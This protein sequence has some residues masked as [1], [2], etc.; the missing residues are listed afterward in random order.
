MV[1]QIIFFRNYFYEFFDKQTPKTQKK[2]DFVLDLVA[3]ADRIPEQ[4]FKHLEG[5]AGLYEIRVQHGNNAF[6][7]FCCFDQGK[8][9]VLFNGFVKETDKT[10]KQELKRAERMKQEYFNEKS[11]TK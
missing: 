5:T 10:P 11:K 4:Y 3:F 9:V 6:R 8:V 7:I 2:I 1:R